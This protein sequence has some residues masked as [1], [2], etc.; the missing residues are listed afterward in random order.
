MYVNYKQYSNHFQLLKWWWWL[1]H[2]PAC[3]CWIRHHILSPQMC[4]SRAQMVNMVISAGKSALCGTW[5][6]PS[7]QRLYSSEHKLYRYT[8]ETSQSTKRIYEAMLSWGW[9]EEADGV[10]LA[11]QWT[12]SFCPQRNDSQTHEIQVGNLPRELHPFY[13]I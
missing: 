2:V 3:K 12:H 9:S 6:L 1:A 13:F 8:T 10:R 4:D 7:D 5:T 11:L